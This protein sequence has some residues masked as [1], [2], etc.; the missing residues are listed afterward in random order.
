MLRRSLEAYRAAGGVEGLEEDW[1]AAVESVPHDPEP[2][3][4][5]AAELA[6]SGEEARAR[7]LLEL[8]DAELTRRG[9]WSTRLELLRRSGSLT[10][11]FPK[12]QKEM[13]ATLERAHPDRADLPQLIAHAGLNRTLETPQKLFDAWTRLE[14]L[15]SYNQGS[16]VEVSGQGVGWIREVNLQL[17]AL[18]IELKNGKSVSIGFRAA[19]KL[20]RILPPENFWR[21]QLEAPEELEALAKTDEPSQL[22]RLV[23]ESAGRPLTAAEIRSA[24]G[25]LIPEKSWNRWWAQ[26]RKHPNVVAS[27]EGRQIYRWEGSVESARR[28]MV[29]Q[30]ERASPREKLRQ[31]RQLSERFPDLAKT[32]AGDLASIA[33]EGAEQEPGLAFE[34][35]FALERIGALPEPLKELVEALL[36]SESDPVS[37]IGGVE[38]RLLRERALLMIRERRSDWLQIWQRWFLR[39]NDPRVLNTLSQALAEEDR[40]KLLRLADDILAAPHRARAQF[41]WL[42]ERAASDREL[43]ERSPLRLLQQ[44]LQALAS[45]EFTFGHA[46]LRALIESGATVPRLLAV[47]D[48]DQAESAREAIQKSSALAEYERIPLLNTLSLRFRSSESDLATDALRALPSSIDARREELRKLIEVE[49]PANRQAIA[50]ARALGDLRENF[51]Y[52]AARQRHEYLNARAA[53]LHRDLARVVPIEI[54]EP[55][56]STVAVGTQLVLEPKEPSQAARGYA[57]LGPWESDPSRGVLSYESEIAK[58]L[59]GKAVGEEVELDDGRYQIARIEPWRDA[60]A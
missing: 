59:L 49:I 27:S 18:K 48:T 42:A 51:E 8:Y 19:G 7:S 10:V 26:A 46:R 23:L 6:K 16:I 25:N 28:A 20:I 2:F 52:K 57:V 44:I 58:L 33:M 34:I 29:V 1:L 39:E 31:L 41:V 3:T 13:L 12:L 40:P 32:V 35:W 43:L 38:D 56:V 9:M 22:L 60:S 50:E 11:R 4:A 17:E 24:L 54:S 36:G 47:L 37:L 45:E 55:P 30:M 15:L 53:Q 21:R 14:C 5:L